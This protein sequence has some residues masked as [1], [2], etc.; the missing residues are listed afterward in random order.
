MLTPA[1]A[2]NCNA[3]FFSALG[4]AGA[5]LSAHNAKFDETK[6]GKGSVSPQGTLLQGILGS[7]SDP[8][9]EREDPEDQE[10]RRQGIK[11]LREDAKGGSEPLQGEEPMLDYLLGGSQ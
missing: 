3:R 1:S 4:D 5:D 2:P 6:Q 7:P 8:A 9:Q 10:Q 11:R